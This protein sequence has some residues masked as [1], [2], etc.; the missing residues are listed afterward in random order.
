[1]PKAAYKI[2]WSFPGCQHEKTLGFKKGKTMKIKY[3]PA[4][5]L[6][7]SLSAMSA[8]AQDVDRFTGYNIGTSLSYGEADR[9]WIGP[10]QPQRTD[11]GSDGGVGLGIQAGYS[12]AVGSN[13][14]VG[15]DIGYTSS[16]GGDGASNCRAARGGQIG[17]R[18]CA[19][20]V[21]NVLTAGARIGAVTNGFLL[22]GKAG[23]ASAEISTTS[24]PGSDPS[25][26]SQVPPID[27]SERQHGYY[28]GLGVERAIDEN[29]SI[30]GDVTY[31]DFNEK[32]HSI[33]LN[34]GFSEQRLDVGANATIFSLSLNYRF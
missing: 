33:V 4:T 7:L 18:D 12:W 5:A 2:A 15:A 6:V 32:T 25:F 3:L 19:M 1:M 10:N 21:D 31:Y 27:S 29:W 28:V 34:T 24:R 14:I 22:Y 13:M 11:L 30:G 9:G 8:T 26:T 20:G 17:R 16:L 23:L